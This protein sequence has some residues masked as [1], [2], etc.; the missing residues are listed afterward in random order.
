MATTDPRK[1][2]WAKKAD[3]RGQLYI[4][5]AIGESFWG[6]GISAQ[7][8]AEVMAEVEDSDALDIYINS[9]GGSVFEGIA[10]YAMLQRYKKEKVV[11]VDGIAASIASVIMLAADRRVITRSAQ[12]MIH[13]P[14]GG[15]MGT[16]DDL[17]KAA[18]SLDGIHESIL[19]TYVARTRQDRKQLD[20]WMRAE[21][22]MRADEAMEHGF[23]TEVTEEESE[24][25]TAS[26]DLLAKFNFKNAPRDLAQT[27]HRAP[28]KTAS[29]LAT[30]SMTVQQLRKAGASPG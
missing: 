11:Y 22:W 23:A 10:I 27:L 24:D 3:K 6:G 30:M 14:W 2:F 12:V 19:D 5:D 4:Y 29:R 17:R 16:A 26:L 8:F 18:D 1:R 9:P 25:A 13:E 20:K 7:R 28:L 15:G 21:T